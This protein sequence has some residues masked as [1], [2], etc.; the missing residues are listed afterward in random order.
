MNTNISFPGSKSGYA[1]KLKSKHLRE[2][3]LETVQLELENQEMEQKLRQLRLNMSREKEERERSNGCHWKSGQAASVGNQNQ[4]RLQNK[5]NSGKASTGKVKLKMIKEQIQEPVKQPVIPKTTKT[6]VTE[7]PKVK[8]NACGQCE[9]KSALLV[10]LE[11]GE[12]YCTSCYAKFH[13][14]GALKLHRTIPFQAKS[15]VPIGKLD[16]ANQFKKDV[17]SHKSTLK[18]EQKNTHPFSRNSSSSILD[19]SVDTEAASSVSLRT[20]S[21]N[22]SGGLLLNGDFDEEESAESFKEILMEWRKGNQECKER[23]NTHESEPESIG[24]SEVQT[25]LSAVKKTLRIEFKENGLTYLEKLLLKKHRRTSIGHIPTMHY[26]G[27]FKC[28]H[29]FF[30]ELQDG[31]SGEDDGLTAEEIEAHEQYSALFRAEESDKEPERP[32]SSLKIVELDDVCELKLEESKTFLVDETDCG[33]SDIEQRS[34]PLSENQNS[35]GWNEDKSESIPVQSNHVTCQFSPCSTCSL[36]IEDFSPG[37]HDSSTTS[38]EDHTSASCKMSID[39]DGYSITRSS[40]DR[41]SLEKRSSHIGIHLDTATNENSLTGL[42][43]IALRVKKC[44]TSEY[45]GLKGFF[46][47]GIDPENTR[48]DSFHS[49]TS[50]YSFTDNEISFADGEWRPNYSF[51]ENADDLI[52][53]N[54]LSDALNR[55]SR[56]FGPQ[57]LSTS[58]AVLSPMHKTGLGYSSPRCLS[59]NPGRQCSRSSPSPRPKTAATRPLSRAAI[60]ISE[61]E[62]IDVTEQDDPLLDEAADQQTIAG[63]EKELNILNIH[64]GDRLSLQNLDYDPPTMS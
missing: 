27:E 61:I 4:V 13:Q 60:E 36:K 51:S 11:C 46:I 15:Q 20:E 50:K 5:E 48:P 6:A 44:A 49:R 29:S 40:E 56:S 21:K 3:R 57:N 26:Q 41:H 54:I 10:C 35:P 37:Y 30:D 1:A 25:V 53:Q 43:E 2:L 55:T 42:Q 33:D 19:Q 24:N 22:Q 59:A 28:P 47:I 34:G 58:V 16:V 62:S 31:L 38:L 23:E 14:K 9:T 45:Q 8:G 63:L 17:T 12:D 32:E 7:R 18:H 39:T 64:A 52:V